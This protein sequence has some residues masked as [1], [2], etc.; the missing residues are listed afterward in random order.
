MN[1][2]TRFARQLDARYRESF[3]GYNLMVNDLYL[4]VVYRPATDK[5]LSFF[6]KQERET[7]DEKAMRQSGAVKAL[8]DINRTLGAA[9]RRYGGELLST[10]EH[11]GHV[12][13]APLEFLALL[14]NGGTTRCRC[15]ATLRELHGTQ[16]TVL[17]QIRVSWARSARR[18][19]CAGSACSRSSNTTTA[20]NR[21]SSMFC[22]SPI[23]SSC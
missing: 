1:S 9:L 10:Y 5:V 7:A 14:V 21:V 16:S 19:A 12:Y 20:P 23:S 15:A 4:T 17:L 2:I 22:W 3:T 8:D 11:K 6:A 13:S 18:T